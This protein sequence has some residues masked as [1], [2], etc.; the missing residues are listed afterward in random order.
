MGKGKIAEKIDLN[1]EKLVIREEDRLFIMDDLF[2]KLK[3]SVVSLEGYTSLFLNEYGSGL[4]TKGKH[5]IKRIQGNMKD[6][7]WVI[8]M[9]QECIKGTK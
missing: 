7:D 8:R 2:H 6:I 1:Y 5:Y 3:S 9:L 4:D